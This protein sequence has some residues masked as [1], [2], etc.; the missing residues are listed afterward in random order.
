MPLPP[1]TE[2]AQ[3]QPPVKPGKPEKS[4]A[5]ETAPTLEELVK[6][7]FLDELLERFPKFDEFYHQHGVKSREA[8]RKDWREQY[9]EH[10]EWDYG[11]RTKRMREWITECRDAG[12]F[13]GGQLK[14][15]PQFP[16]SFSL[17]QR[18]QCRDKG[19]EWRLGVVKQVDPLRVRPDGAE[20]GFNWKDA[21]WDEVRPLPFELGQQVRCR[22]KGTGWAVGRVKG[23]DPLRVELD[24]RSG[25][26]IWDEV[27]ALPDI[28]ALPD[29]EVTEDGATCP[30]S[31]QPL[32]KGSKAVQLP[33]GC[34]FERG[35][36]LE[37]FSRQPSCPLCRDDLCTAP[38][39]ADVPARRHPI[40]VGSLVQLV[41][42]DSATGLNGLTGHVR[43]FTGGRVTVDI[44]GHGAKLL[45]PACVIPAP[46][47]VPCAAPGSPSAASQRSVR[48]LASTLEAPPVGSTVEIT[49]LTG[50]MLGLN[51]C[52][53]TVLGYKGDRVAVSLGDLGKKLF[54]VQ[55]CTLDTAPPAAPAETAPAAAAAAEHN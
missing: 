22:D 10:P 35:A 18:V 25:A 6:I 51:H 53:G 12:L 26:H 55:N 4:L 49:G 20:A 31:L 52:K 36:L 13:N 5:D 32:Q 40:A 43:G 21:H 42:V 28:A 27:Q 41:G 11:G 8:M 23:F 33:C 45:P 17:G 47:T 30:I 24:G 15:K 16:S 48:S 38:E 29:T 50:S 1:A 3:H 39:K 37:W 54:R 19:E 14:G 34:R 44:P 2:G 7:E 9:R 46:G